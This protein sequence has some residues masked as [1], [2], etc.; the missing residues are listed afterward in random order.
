MK[1]LLIIL[2][3][4]SMLMLSACTSK[5]NDTPDKPDE[6]NVPEFGEISHN[7]LKQI[8]HESGISA[9]LPENM[10]QEEIE[11]FTVVYVND[12]ALFTATKEDVEMLGQ[13]GFD[14][15]DFGIEDYTDAIVASNNGKISFEEGPD[16][17]PFTRYISTVECVKYS[18][19]TILRAGTDAFW[20]ITFGC[21]TEEEETYYPLFEEWA[22]MV[23]VE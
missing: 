17:C 2:M 21:L 20:T 4:L 13:Y 8:S 22:L 23:E 18:Y 12:H 10:G 19:H 1:K 3:A 16:G 11:G 6:I 14:M 5:G 15:T 7:G 9:W